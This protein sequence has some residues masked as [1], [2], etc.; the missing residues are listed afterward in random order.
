MVEMHIQIQHHFCASVP[1]SETRLTTLRQSAEIETTSSTEKEKLVFRRL[2]NSRSLSE[3]IKPNGVFL[4]T[5]CAL[6][7]QQIAFLP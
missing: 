2:K 5:A 6:F 4:Q 7:Q 3:K 1:N